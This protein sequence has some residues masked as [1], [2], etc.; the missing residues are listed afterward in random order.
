MRF[1]FSLSRRDLM[2]LGFFSFAGATIPLFS[3]CGSNSTSDTNQIPAYLSGYEDL[4]LKDPKLASLAWFAE[5]KYGLIIHYGLC[6]L[7]GKNGWVMKNE[8]I[9]LKEY[10]QLMDL[11]TADKFNADE[12][13][14]LAVL[15]GMKYVTFTAKHHE[16]FCHWDTKQT[17]F[18][19]MNTPA[20]RD[21][22]GELARACA[23]RGL[24]FFLYY[25]YSADWH[26]PY[27]PG[28]EIL[29]QARDRSDD[30]P[31]MY[32]L[33]K[34]EDI[35]FYIDYVHAQITELLTNYGSIAG[36]WLDPLVYYYMRRDFFPVQKL[37]DLINKLQPQCLVSFK[38]GAV[39][40][41][42]FV[43]PEWGWGPF[44]SN[45]LSADQLEYASEI[46]ELGR[47]KQ[48]QIAMALSNYFYIP[49]SPVGDEEFLWS[50]LEAARSRQVNLLTGT[51]LMGDGALQQNE[52]AILKNVGKRLSAEGFPKIPAGEIIDPPPKPSFVRVTYPNGGENLVVS[53]TG[54]ITWVS[55][56]T[57]ENFTVYYRGVDQKFHKIGDT[58]QNYLEWELPNTPSSEYLIHVD[59][60]D[61]EGNFLGSDR[62]DGPFSLV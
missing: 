47:N 55:D 25:S 30:P 59:A 1:S 57:S 10:V 19:I 9:P 14:E 58:T 53:T 26:H 42:D 54:T 2:K 15:S 45:W 46:W 49:G 17:D 35:S 43:A 50:S 11:F 18:N 36:I 22:V 52:V 61:A 24:G 8:N 29:P 12:I 39:G 28:A 51:G 7:L 4:Y 31:D 44:T 13:A 62:S 41:E 3:G 48:G 21:L 6:S 20:E 56:I 32:L 40:T 27:F 60:F 23:H 33:K 16:G 34:E 38:H 37:Y 5:A